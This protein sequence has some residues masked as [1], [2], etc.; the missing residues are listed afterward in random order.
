MHP[1]RPQKILVVAP[2]RDT[3]GGITSV[4][5]LHSRADVWQAMNCRLLSTHDDRGKWRKLTAALKAYIQA[6]GLVG[7]SSLVHVHLAGEM[8]LMRKLPIIALAK[9]MR[10]PVIV[11]VHAQSPES[12]FIDTPRWAVNYAFRN[13]D[14]VIALSQN[15]A[16]MIRRRSP[17]SNVVIVP[18]PVL[19]HRCNTP[20]GNGCQ[21]VLFVGKLE[22]RKGYADL[23][24]AAKIVHA[25]FP[26]VQFWFAGHGE[27]ENAGRLAKELGLEN[28]IR[29]LGWVEEEALTQMWGQATIFCLPSH[30]EGVPMAVLEAMSHGV[31]VVCTPVGGLPELIEDGRN[32]LFARPADPTSIAEAILRLLRDEA[33]QK[34]I[35]EA[36]YRTVH[37]KC[38]LQTVSDRLRTIYQE[39]LLKE[40]KA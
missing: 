34:S 20:S 28:S 27:L 13:A 11:H 14:L 35:G 10:R 16:E 3:R 37:Q 9:A 22:A 7:K 33:L 4:I 40:A 31:P 19:A 32:G 25:A 23:I 18:N 39:L 6:P 38:G 24:Q 5:R 17:A 1:R 21:R 12:L 36:G 29:L 15:W 30:N 2:G 8:S 26:N